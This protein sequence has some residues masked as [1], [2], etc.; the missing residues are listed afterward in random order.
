MKSAV[1]R[2]SLVYALLASCIAAASAEARTIILDGQSIDRMAA[3]S[4]AAPRQS[5]AMFEPKTGAFDTSKVSLASGH[6]FLAR[7]SL[8]RIPPGQRIAHAELMLPVSDYSGAEARF[9]VWRLTAPW[10]LG[11][12]HLYRSTRPQRA[13]WT[14]PGAH[15][16]SSDRATRPT[17]IVRLTA[18]GEMT[19][20]VTED[21]DLWYSGAAG[22]EGWLLTVEDPATVANFVSPLSVPAGQAA[23]KLRIT[24]EPK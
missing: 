9:Y 15:G 17:D 5:W 18:P 4:A 12:S 24:Y 8:A 23:W 10:G 20:N 19:I 21:V 1:A 2:L 22:N 3:L 14:K 16:Y 13:E 11:V 7:F 6:S